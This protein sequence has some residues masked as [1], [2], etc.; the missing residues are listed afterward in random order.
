VVHI[1]RFGNLILNLRLEDVR[2]WPDAQTA[3]E[4]SG[5][6]LLGLH[7]TFADVASGMPVAYLGSSGYLELGVRDGSAA[8]RW[9]VRAGARV[10]VYRRDP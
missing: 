7:R 6:T 1:D 5:Q 2:I 8:E 9:G 3:F 10:R 4:V